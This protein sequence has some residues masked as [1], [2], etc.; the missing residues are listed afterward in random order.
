MMRKTMFLLGG[1]PPTFLENFWDPSYVYWLVTKA[2]TTPKITAI[3]NRDRKIPRERKKTRWKYQKKFAR[4][5][6]WSFFGREG[7][8]K[9]YIIFVKYENIYKWRFGFCLPPLKLC[10]CLFLKIMWKRNEKLC[11]MESF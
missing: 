9:I 5:T 1:G 11:L 6:K 8:K 10:K 3:T 4:F 2:H 7:R